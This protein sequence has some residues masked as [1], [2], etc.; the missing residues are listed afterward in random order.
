MK[1]LICWI[2]NTDLS[3]AERNEADNL[4]PIAQAL[5]HGNYARA[6]LLDNYCNERTNQFSQWVKSH[7][8]T[9]IN[10]HAIR[11]T[12]PTNH[13]EIYEAAR[14]H[15]NTIHTQNPD[16]KLTFHISPGTPAMALTWTLLAPVYGAQLIESSREHGVQVVQFPFEIAAYFLPD[17][18]LTRLTEN[19]TPTHSAFS[20]ILFQSDIMRKTILQA[21]HVASR[22]ITVLIEGESGTGKELF[23]RAIHNSSSRA[24][25]AFIAV[26]C[27][28]IPGELIEST[29]FGYKKGSF[30][31]ATKDKK[32]LFHD[33]DKGTLFLDELGELPL[34][35]QVALLRALQEKAVTRI[36]DSKSEPVDV[37]I[38]AATNRNLLEEVAEGRFRSDLFYRL[39]VACLSLPPLRD[40]GEDINVLLED[41]TRKANQELSIHGNEI[42]RKISD[43]AKKVMFQHSWP[44]NIRELYNTV[45]RAILWTPGDIVDAESAKQALFQLPS[46]KTAVLEHPLGNGFSIKDLLGEIATVYVSRANEE[47][48]GIKAKAAKL[49]GFDNYQTFSNWQNKYQKK[50]K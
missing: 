32:G 47:A 43:S 49:L 39:A 18:E 34:K 45:I 25:K 26:N 6:V 33:A 46:S 14:G 42:H 24:E 36:G 27:G 9:P 2:G 13:K 8:T 7:T 11:L 50:D 10:I 37:R 16:A 28:A 35:A 29:L 31:G 20:N 48:G 30:T 4:G 19:L 5:K 3:C 38:I 17:R 12:S 21:Q 22:D 44:G 15:V 40:R 23:A 1:I 41:A